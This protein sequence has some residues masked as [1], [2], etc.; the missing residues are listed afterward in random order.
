M[1][2]NMD[3]VDLDLVEP[4]RLQM[5]KEI[6]SRLMEEDSWDSYFKYAETDL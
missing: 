4:M 2:L 5:H 6:H 1:E 3:K